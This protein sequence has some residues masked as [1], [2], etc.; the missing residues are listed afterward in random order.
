MQLGLGEVGLGCCGEAEVCAVERSVAQ[1]GAGHERIS[2]I[3]VVEQSIIKLR[4][5]KACFGKIC[6]GEVAVA[7][8]HAGQVSTG[9][10]AAD[11][12]FA[13]EDAV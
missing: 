6:A 9:E 3:S 2:E 4:A 11:A 8:V 10:V 7:E 13:V 5:V 12:V 1:A